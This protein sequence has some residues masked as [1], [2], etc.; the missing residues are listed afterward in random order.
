MPSTVCHLRYA[1][2]GTP[3][4]VRQL[5]YAIYG[6]VIPRFGCEG[7]YDFRLAIGGREGEGLRRKGREGEGGCTGKGVYTYSSVIDGRTN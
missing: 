3:I 5:R 6:S 2:Y 7:G 4:K 1:N